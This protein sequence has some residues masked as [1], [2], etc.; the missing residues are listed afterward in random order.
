[1]TTLL[2]IAGTAACTE[3]EGPHRRFA[4]WVQGCTLDCAGC[5]NPEMFVP[6]AGRMLDVAALD[7]VIGE[8]QRR[9]GLE[10][11]TVLGG[12]PLQQAEGVASLC[13]LAVARSLGVIVFSGYTHEQA[14]ARAGFDRLWAAVDTLVDGRFEAA[15]RDESRRFLGSRNQRLIHRTPRYAEPTLWVG[16]PSVELDIA[17]GRPALVVGSP[18]L[19][20]R[21]RRLATR[22]GGPDD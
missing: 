3:V 19:A 4:V 5:C 18:A 15:L 6:G 13:E 16:G 12:E 9:W 11:L 17:A 7:D 10:G 1:M 22:A 14:Q 2:E 20:R 21:V 8:A